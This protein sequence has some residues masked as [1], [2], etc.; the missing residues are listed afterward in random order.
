M[1]GACGGRNLDEARPQ[2]SVKEVVMILVY[3]I[4]VIVMFAGAVASVI[5]ALN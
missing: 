1:M 5:D 2:F 4:L 3:I